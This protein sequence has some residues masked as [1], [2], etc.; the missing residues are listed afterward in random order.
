VA[1]FTIEQGPLWGGLHGLVSSAA[2]DL[3]AYD[4]E[5]WQEPISAAER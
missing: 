2:A 4:V 5:S 1:W 3:A